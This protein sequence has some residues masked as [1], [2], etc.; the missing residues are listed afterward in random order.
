LG[1]TGGGYADAEG[2]VTGI[3]QAARAW[4]NGVGAAA[5]SATAQVINDATFVAKAT[6]I[7]TGYQ[8]DVF[9]GASAHGITQ[10]AGAT[11]S[12]EAAANAIV[13]NG[14]TI[15]VLANADAK[16][17]GIGGNV[18]DF[19]RAHAIAS[20]ISQRATATQSVDDVKAG[21]TALASVTNQG[22]ILV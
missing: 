10:Y 16:A 17:L 20:G 6:A 4:A 7:A 9:A 21:A 12:L 18:D 22:L 1:S 11:A 2:G 3:T 19:V 15:S 8:S 14:G 5:A 13:H